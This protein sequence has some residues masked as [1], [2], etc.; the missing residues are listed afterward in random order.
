MKNLCL[1]LCLPLSTSISPS[2]SPYLSLSLSPSLHIGCV[3]N[4]LP[5]GS[6]HSLVLM[7][8]HYVTC[9]H[10]DWLWP[11]SVASFSISEQ[12]SSKISF[13]HSLAAA[14]IEKEIRGV[15]V[16]VHICSS[17]TGGSCRRWRRARQTRRAHR[18]SLRA[19]TSSLTE[20]ACRP[21]AEGRWK[22]LPI[23]P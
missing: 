10:A 8:G 15:L 3:D 4:V 23:S 22:K 20:C 18:L 2:P 14:L 5:N 19:N 12:R 7:R 11:V 16:S 21:F 13:Q 1:S 17:G 9:L 6:A